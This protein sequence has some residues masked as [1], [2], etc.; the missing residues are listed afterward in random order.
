MKKV[1]QIGTVFAGVL[2]GISVFVAAPAQAKVSD[3][4]QLIE[5]NISAQKQLHGE[6]KKQMNVARESLSPRPV[7]KRIVE[8]EPAQINAPT[9]Q[10]FL[11]Y[12]KEKVVRE[13]S[14]KK[15]L[16]RLSQE[17]DDA[18]SSF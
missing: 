6:V 5:D 12:K 18:N 3:F 7:S 17:L 11:R 1:N 13:F 10:A 2:M 14:G 16:D 8:G 15:Q 4:G 9:S